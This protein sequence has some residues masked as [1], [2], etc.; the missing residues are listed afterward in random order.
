MIE[1]DLDDFQNLNYDI[2]RETKE[3][4]LVQGLRLLVSSRR[5]IVVIMVTSGTDCSPKINITHII[6][7]IIN[8]VFDRRK[9]VTLIFNSKM[10]SYLVLF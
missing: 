4:L 5:D 1:V 3:R 7:Q 10:E 6:Q 9:T 2:P 8:K